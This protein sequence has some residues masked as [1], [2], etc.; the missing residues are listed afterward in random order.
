MR[1][2]VSVADVR[3]RARERLSPIGHSTPQF[4][5][6][7]PIR[8]PV[9]WVHCL[10]LARIDAGL[11][12]SVRRRPR[13]PVHAGG[14][15]RLPR[16]VEDE[17][18]AFLRCGVLAHGF[19]RV[20]CSACGHGM[21]LAFS[22]KRRAV[23]PSCTGRRAA[24]CAA[25][26][27]DEVLARTPVRQWVLTFPRH[28]RFA[29]ARDSRLATKVIAVWLRALDGFH[30]R[31]ARIAGFSFTLTGAVTFVQRFGSALN[32][33]VHLHTVVPDG[34]FTIEDRASFVSLSPPTSAESEALLLARGVPRPALR[35]A[36][37][38]RQ[39]RRSA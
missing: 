13:A 35:C 19:A 16:F 28:V 17:L 2:Y 9:Q 3:Q 24:D 11:Q 32:L 38:R 15:R 25:H 34:T 27:V 12:Q 1:A 10:E 37:K 39:R 26:L 33:N 29:L 30:R 36:P 7:H 20:R 4:P 8:G 18:R 23:C 14:H 6:E 21:L 5:R 22:C 31:R